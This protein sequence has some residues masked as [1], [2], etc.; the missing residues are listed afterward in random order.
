MTI[1]LQPYATHCM[2]NRAA[3]STVLEAYNAEAATSAVPQPTTADPLPTDIT[4]MLNIP[5]FEEAQP[6]LSSLSG[7]FPLAL[8][9]SE[10][11]SA[12]RGI[13][14]ASWQWAR[15]AGIE[16]RR[17]PAEMELVRRA[18]TGTCRCR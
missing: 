15:Q 5:P 18:S 13:P 3:W 4:S 6:P 17:L 1:E 10:R 14:N 16:G 12:A 11:G 2:Q 9:T 8:P 7:I